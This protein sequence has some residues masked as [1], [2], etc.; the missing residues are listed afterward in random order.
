MKYNKNPKLIDKET[1][2]GL[3]LFNVDSGNMIEL[4]K[5]ARL[6]WQKSG[7]SFTLEDLKKIVEENCTK[8][9]DVDKDLPE[10]VEN[11]KKFKLV[12]ADG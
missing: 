6:L 3:L 5:M 7:D 4:D 12:D 11:A 8:I 1:E 9:G 2:Q 10:F